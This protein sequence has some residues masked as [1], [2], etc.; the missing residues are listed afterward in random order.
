MAEHS[1][2]FLNKPHVWHI[3]EAGNGPLLLLIHGAGGATQSWRHLFP[4][5][6]KTHRVIAI[7]L[8][9]QGFTKLGA[10]Q[11][12][13]LVEMA[14][15]ITHLCVSQNWRPQA[16][17]GH[18]AG[19]AIALQMVDKNP[20]LTRKVI[21]I[22]S[23]LDNF[24]GLAGVFFPIMAKTLAML[25]M[26]ADLFSASTSR[27][28]SG[29]KLINATGSKLEPSD[30]RFYQ[31]LM[32]DRQHINATLQ[33]MSQW[34]LDPL[35]NRLNMINTETLLLASDGDLM[36]PIDV[37]K[38][39]ADKLPNTEF[40]LIAGLGHLAHEEDPKMI[41]KELACFLKQ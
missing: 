26:V 34:K 16:I 35:I 25:P 37:T 19:T 39:A 21:G 32:S 36:V 20:N 6:A 38:K 29:Q 7:D 30:M 28:N 17:I 9:G 13:G 8:P 15:D 14:E 24:K 11:R 27:A 18:S 4:L 23:A 3:Q 1:R 5:L 10:Q 40:R 22:N 31:S 33:M 12:C 2:F 41:I